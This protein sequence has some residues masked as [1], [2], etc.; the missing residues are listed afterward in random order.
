MKVTI[1]YKIR[2]GVHYSGMFKSI[3]SESYDEVITTVDESELEIKNGRYYYKNYK[4]E[5]IIRNS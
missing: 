4:V 1:K 3:V 5:Y 2:T